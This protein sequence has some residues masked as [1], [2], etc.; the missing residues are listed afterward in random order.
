MGSAPIFSSIPIKVG[1]QNKHEVGEYT[2]SS[3]YILLPDRF[4]K[5][6]FSSLPFPGLAQR[7][8]ANVDSIS[9]V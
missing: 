2:K 7:G 8:Q 1:G 6:F 5:A 9:L 4:V 3:S